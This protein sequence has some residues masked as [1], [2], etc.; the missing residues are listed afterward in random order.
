EGIIAQMGSPGEIYRRPKSTFV[1]DFIGKSNIFQ[2]KPLG[3][4]HRNR[5][6]SIADTGLEL[7]IAAIPTNSET[8][9]YCCIRP[10]AL[11]WSGAPVKDNGDTNVLDV[12][13]TKIVNLGAYLEVWT[14]HA[15]G[16]V[17][18]ALI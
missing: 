13:I 5:R 15:S 2:I 10:E 3:R 11:R 17:F 4:A 7:E 16:T 9:A 1:A 12:Q 14:R 18:K 8:V 6:I